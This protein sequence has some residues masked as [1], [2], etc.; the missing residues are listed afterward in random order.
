MAAACKGVSEET[1]TG[2][3]KLQLM[4]AKGEFIFPAI[5]VNDCVIK[6]NFDVCGSSKN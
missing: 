2:M 3:H 1:I 6:P 4:V 5:N